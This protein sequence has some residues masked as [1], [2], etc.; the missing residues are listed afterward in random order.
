MIMLSS[1]EKAKKSQLVLIR[2]LPLE[3]ISYN[4]IAAG[5]GRLFYLVFKKGIV[6]D[7]NGLYDRTDY[8]NNLHNYHLPI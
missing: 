6:D 3:Q 7:S 2:R 5:S 1:P 8:N 4:R